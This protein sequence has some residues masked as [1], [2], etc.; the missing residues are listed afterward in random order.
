[1]K[2][3]LKKMLAD[4]E[5]DERAGKDRSNRLLTQDEIRQMARAK[6]AGRNAAKA[7]K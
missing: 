6:R 7:P 3:D 4:I 5:R 2:Y 1:M